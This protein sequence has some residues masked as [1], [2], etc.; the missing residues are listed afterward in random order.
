MTGSDE[1]LPL[2]PT[3]RRAKPVA[4]ACKGMYRDTSG[5]CGLMLRARRCR[6]ALFGIKAPLAR[7]DRAGPAPR[8]RPSACRA[9]AGRTTLRGCSLMGAVAFPSW[10]Q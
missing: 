7:R 5:C 10:R 8:F 1:Y 2:D 4:R 3:I 9:P 6:F